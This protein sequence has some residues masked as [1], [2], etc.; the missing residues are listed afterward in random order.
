MGA[1][2]GVTQNTVATAPGLQLVGR[3]IGVTGRT[4]TIRP[5]TDRAAGSLRAMVMLDEGSNG[6]LTNLS[7]IMDGTLQGDVED[8]RT[9]DGKPIEPQVGQLVRLADP[10]WPKNA[11]MLLVGKVEQ[12]LP[13]PAQ[14]LRR[15]V[16][17]RP[18]IDRLDRLSEVVLRVTPQADGEEGRP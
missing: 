16:V 7:P 4:A 11:D 14:P 2:Q 8:R 18:T 5:I 15:M 6:L 1:S 17:V 3:V 12:V 10:R 9:P 13:S